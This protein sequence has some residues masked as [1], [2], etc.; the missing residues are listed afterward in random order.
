MRRSNSSGL[1]LSVLGLMAAL[2]VVPAWAGGSTQVASISGCYG[3]TGFDTPALTFIIPSGITL[4]NAQMVLL[5]YQG[6]NNGDTATVALGTLSGT[7]SFT[8]GSL[9]GGVSGA[10]TPHNLTAG[11]YDDE[12]IGTSA[13]INSATCGGGG[14]VGDGGSQWYAQT[15]NFQVTFTANVSG[16]GYTGQ[17]VYSVFSPTHNATGGFV[18]W[19]GLDQNG[20]SE[21]P[22]YDLHQGS[23]TGN[24]AFISLGTPS[25]TVPEPGSLALLGV[26]L[27]LLAL[28]VIRRKAARVR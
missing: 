6:Q 13:I 20:Y 25:T 7:Q 23:L 5:G 27:G 12:F 11:D 24:M 4:T 19:E 8:W 16:N 21:S 28:A 3:C 18:G 22:T 10:L 1:W 26:G 17:S 9:P 2:F 15:G 14:C